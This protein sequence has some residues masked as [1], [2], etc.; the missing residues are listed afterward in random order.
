MKLLTAFT[1]FLICL[2]AIGQ[3]S[4]MNNDKRQKPL[5]FYPGTYVDTEARWT[6]STGMALI[7]QN[8]LPKGGG[9]YTDPAGKNY[10]YVVFWTRVINETTSPVELIISFPADSFAIFPSPGSDLK[11]FLPPDTMTLDKESLYDYGFTGLKSFLDTSFNKPTTLRKTIR[12]KQD[13]IFYIL[14]LF[15]EARGT[16][17]SGLVL[18]EQELFY[19]ISLGPDSA[20]IPCG[21]IVLKN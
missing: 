12:P 16:A 15:Y 7:I 9:G 1:L 5:T 8:S 11:L 18:Q 10:G 17:R 2:T 21:Q 20:L 6:D 14:A 3:T 4:P 19:R 13:G